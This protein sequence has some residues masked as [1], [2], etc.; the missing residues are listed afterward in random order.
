[1]DAY[2]LKYQLGITERNTWI[3]DGD[4]TGL[5]EWSKIQGGN[6]YMSS[7]HMYRHL[8]FL[9]NLVSSIVSVGIP[10]WSKSQELPPDQE[11][12]HSWAE[13]IFFRVSTMLSNRKPMILGLK[14]SLPLTR[15]PAPSE[16]NFGSMPIT[17]VADYAILTSDRDTHSEVLLFHSISYIQTPLQSH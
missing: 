3:G 5:A 10:R 1:M 9:E 11:T 7:S 12:A 8:N 17:G 6:Y 14:Q 13:T 15:I 2:S 16:L 4:Y